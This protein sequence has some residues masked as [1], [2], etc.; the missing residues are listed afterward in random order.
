[1]RKKALSQIISNRLVM[2]SAPLAEGAIDVILTSIEEALFRH[3]RVEIRGFGVFTLRERG[4]RF[5][6]NP[7]T[8][9]SWS[10]DACHAIHFKPGKLL[11]AAINPQETIP[12]SAAQTEHTV[13]SNTK[14]SADAEE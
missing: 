4:P 12:T 2:K 10:T 14:G 3:K 6:R 11:K 5:A 13:V 7:V 8:G 9:D 1:M